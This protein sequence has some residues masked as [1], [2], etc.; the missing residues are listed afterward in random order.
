MLLIVVDAAPE[1]YTARASL[2][3]GSNPHDGCSRDE[4]GSSPDYAQPCATR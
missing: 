4:V 2:G 1:S 3:L